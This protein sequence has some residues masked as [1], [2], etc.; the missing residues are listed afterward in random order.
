MNRQLTD[1]YKVL[2]DYKGHDITFYAQ[3]NE[4]GE[5]LETWQI[6]DHETGDEI[7]DDHWFTSLQ[8]VIYW[9]DRP[10][11]WLREYR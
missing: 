4:N 11:I 2:T 9:I 6:F 7:R 1:Q 10:E 8:E 3:I 5:V